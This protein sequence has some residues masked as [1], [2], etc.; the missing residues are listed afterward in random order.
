M[1]ASIEG[2]VIEQK[3]DCIV[4][5]VGGVGIQVFVPTHLRS[6]IQLGSR[7]HLHTYLSVREDNLSLFGFLTAEELEFFV[8][9]LGVNGVGPKLALAG[10]STLNPD[11]IRRAVY[12]EQAEIFSRIPGIGKKTAQRILLHLQ[13]KVP[14]GEG[15]ESLSAMD[16][17]D[18]QIMEALVGLGYSVVEA[19]T[20]MQTIPSD[21]PNDLEARIRLA[22]RYFSS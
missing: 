12:S 15:I 16:D 22:L 8:M 6:N 2:Q 14:S 7:V 1:I 18:T 4:V 10:I 11:T 21:A 5:K 17:L 20:A 9:L 13:G 19:Q 3:I